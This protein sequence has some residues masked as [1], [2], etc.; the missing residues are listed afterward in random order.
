MGSAHVRMRP[1]VC[2]VANMSP[3]C[4]VRRVEKGKREKVKSLAVGDVSRGLVRSVHDKTRKCVQYPCA[5]GKD[6]HER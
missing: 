6:H 4:C 5:L 2:S 1:A 3:T